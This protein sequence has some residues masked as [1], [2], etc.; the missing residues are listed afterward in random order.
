MTCYGCNGTGHLY[1]ACPMRRRTEE[2]APTAHATSSADI[3]SKGAGETAKDREDEQK[4]GHSITSQLN[5]PRRTMR[6]S[7]KRTPE[8]GV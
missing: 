4:V 8:T 2:K 3:A 7:G 1:H 5:L 6:T